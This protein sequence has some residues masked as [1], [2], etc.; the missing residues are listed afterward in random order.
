MSGA[1]A[2]PVLHGPGAA[3]Q[4]AARYD[5][6]AAMTPTSRFFTASLA[7]TDP[8]LAA[9]VAGEQ[10]PPAGRNRTHRQ[11]EHRLRRGARS[12]RQR[13]DE[14]IRR[15][16]SRPPLLRR[17]RTSRHRRAPRHRA[18]QIPLR[19]QLRQ[20]AAPFRRSSQPGRLPR[21]HIRRRD[22]PR[23][24]SC[25]RRPP[26]PWRRAQPLRQMVPCHPIRRPPRRRPAR[27][28]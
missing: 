23:H 10:A 17:L 9:A 18:R 11:R 1:L 13:P 8:E 21:T 2:S 24:E 15:G 3:S 7:D 12:P 20:R 25:R 28:R 22:H 19:L 16:L 27:L 5:K 4:N 6:P 14:Q 26:H